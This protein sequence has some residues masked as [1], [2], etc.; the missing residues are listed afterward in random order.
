MRLRKVSGFT[1]IEL[2]VVISIIA[3]LAA[4]LLPAI[5]KAREAARSAQCQANLKN[6]GVGL[7]K[8][9]TRSPGGQFCSG[10]YDLRRDGCPD[11]FGWVADLVNTGEANLNESLDPSNPLLGSEKLNDLLGSDTT[12]G[13]AGAGPDRLSAGVCGQ[14]QWKGFSTASPTTFFGGS[15]NNSPERA[16]LVSRYFVQGGF[17]TNYATGWHL[18]RG[19]VRTQSVGSGSSTY[20]TTTTATTINAISGAVEQPDF[21]ALNGT[22]GPIAARELDRSRIPSSNFG[23]VGCAGPGDID[24][25]VLALDIRHGQAD[26]R[27]Y[28][29]NSDEAAAYI[30]AGSI[31]AE[32]FNDGPAIYDATTRSVRLIQSGAPLVG[33]QL[34]EKGEAT[35]NGCRPAYAA[36]LAA[37][38]AYVPSF[39][40]AD[41]TTAPTYLQDTR[42]WFA[43]HAGAVNVLMGDG[44][45]KVFYDLNNDG[46][47]NPGFP[48]GKDANGDDA[49]PLT[50]D[51]IVD[52]GYADST[53][54]MPR[55]QFYG[56][57]FWSETFF[58]GAFED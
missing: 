20:L 56:G 13:R 38:T 24:E 30:T 41:I 8:F 27:V 39:T 5:T 48:V 1:L 43:V 12:R 42:D 31:L 54:E 50:D 10:A 37:A 9:S 23:F 45:V 33:N 3:L 11:T 57:V 28:N 36:D 52:V 46:Y 40:A 51:E 25:A 58:K 29:P 15:A 49:A 6:I 4:L 7:F 22:V 19:M 16:E 26:R 35:T 21:K 14:S 47:L 2:L 18:S 44:S 53:T 55:D 17:S 32:S 34:C